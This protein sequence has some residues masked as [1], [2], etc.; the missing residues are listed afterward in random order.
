MSSLLVQPKPN[1]ETGMK[2]EPKS[3]MSSRS[4]GTM[5]PL[6]ALARKRGLKYLL[7]YHKYPNRVNTPETARPRKGSPASPRLK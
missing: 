4:S 5:I 3:A 7:R 1:I 2:K 6:A